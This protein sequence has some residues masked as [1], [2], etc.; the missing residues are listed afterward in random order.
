M[1][2]A[3]FIN[4]GRN[5]INETV[6]VKNTKELHKEIGKHI[7]SKGW[8]MEMTNVPNEYSITSGWANVGT[9]LILEE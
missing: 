9:V 8:G 5:N 4:L 7:L 1:I 6:T 3:Q 2:K